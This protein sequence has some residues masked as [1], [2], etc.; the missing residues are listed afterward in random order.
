MPIIPALWEAK[1]GRSRRQKI[2]TILANMAQQS[3]ELIQSKIVKA[4]GHT[5]VIENSDVSPETESSEKETMSVS[6]NQTVTQL[7]QLLQAVNQ[8]LTKEKEHYQVLGTMLNSLHVLPFL[9]KV[10]CCV[11]V[12]SLTLLSRQECSGVIWAHCKPQL[13]NSRDS[14][15]LASR[16]GFCHVAQ[17][18]LELLALS[19]PPVLAS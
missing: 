6:L 8:Q 15:A 3:L 1:V 19:S 10:L 5:T 9:L 18:G 11:L 7:Q 2:E 16:M 14:H 4:A 12:Q 13:P 17:A